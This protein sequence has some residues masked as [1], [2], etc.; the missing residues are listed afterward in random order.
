M[1]TSTVITKKI[2]IPCNI[3]FETIFLYRMIIPFSKVPRKKK[4]ENCAYQIYVT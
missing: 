2:R 1:R 3:N 4:M